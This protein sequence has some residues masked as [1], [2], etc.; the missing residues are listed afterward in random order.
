[1]KVKQYK[2]NDTGMQEI[3]QFLADH[4]QRGDDNFSNDEIFAWAADAEF[5]LG[6]GNSACIEIRASNSRSGHTEIYTISDAGLDCKE[7]ELE[8]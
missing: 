7:I 1:M 2:V 4:H 5:Q 6:E 8:E 3:R